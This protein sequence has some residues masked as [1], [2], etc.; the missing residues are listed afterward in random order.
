MPSPPKGLCVCGGKE[1]EG[2]QT[3]EGAAPLL[4]GLR[5]PLS[6]MSPE[7]PPP[8]PQLS[9]LQPGFTG[10]QLES[11]IRARSLWISLFWFNYIHNM[12]FANRKLHA[13]IIEF[14]PGLEACWAVVCSSFQT[15]NLAPRPHLHL[16]RWELIFKPHFPANG[17]STTPISFEF[18]N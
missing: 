10:V 11:L 2:N 8:T 1:A 9:P 4:P 14:F 13:A 15:L 18:Y 6:A 7:G 5:G 17:A 3:Q 16:A 12:S